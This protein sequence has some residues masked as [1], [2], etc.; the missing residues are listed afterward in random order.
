MGC[1]LVCGWVATDLLACLL[2]YGVEWFGWI[3][4]FPVG[5]V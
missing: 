4:G 3:W 5:L 1:D 2:Y